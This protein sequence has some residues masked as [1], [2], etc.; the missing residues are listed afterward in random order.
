MPDVSVSRTIDA[1]PSAVWALVS[2]PTRMGEWSPENTGAKWLK[3]ATG[4]A[5][6]ARFMGRNKR[7][8]KPWFTICTVTECVENEVFSFDVA[9]GPL[10][11]ASWTY[12]LSAVDGG[13]EVVEETTNREPKAFAKIADKVLGVKSRTEL[14][15]SNMEATLEGIAQTLKASA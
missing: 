2:D 10:P 3:G 4:P 5:V 13:T 7:G 8:W 11:I 1:T 14:N 9:V 6:G 12:R 15:R